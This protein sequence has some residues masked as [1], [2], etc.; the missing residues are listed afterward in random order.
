MKQYSNNVTPYCHCE[1]KN[2]LK[3]VASVIL[4]TID[5]FKIVSEF[6]WLATVS[7]Y[8]HNT[9]MSTIPT[10]CILKMLLSSI[11]YKC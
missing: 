6:I 1:I 3:M 9:K 5:K 8:L 4:Y 2:I 11:K 10:L 7:N